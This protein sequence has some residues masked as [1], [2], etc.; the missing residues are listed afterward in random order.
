MEVCR[1]A[2]TLRAA[3]LMPSIGPK[4]PA[5]KVGVQTGVKPGLGGGGA[6]SVGQP[7]S[8]ATRVIKGHI[9]PQRKSPTPG[10]RY[11]VACV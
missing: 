8:S 9:S 6:I 4:T 10:A 11:V 5:K 7:K 2:A 1:D 3:D